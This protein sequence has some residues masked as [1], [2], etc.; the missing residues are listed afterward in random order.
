MHANLK[1]QEFLDFETAGVGVMA[2]KEPINLREWAACEGAPRTGRLFTCG[3]P[4]R[5]TFGTAR[6]RVDKCTID[7]WV[8]G[9]PEGEVLH[10]ISLLGEKKD[11]FSEFSYYPFRSSKEIGDK[12]TFQDWL[13]EHHGQRLLVDEYPTTDAEAMSP[14]CLEVVKHRVVE[15]MEAGN[16]VV[17]MDSA[18]AVRTARVCEGIGY[19]RLA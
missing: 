4:G 9:L 13:D 10:I 14:T 1:H 17:V 12:P 6:R 3:R 16:T 15:L 8:E 18:G 2:G 7:Q 5:G 11:G 19:R